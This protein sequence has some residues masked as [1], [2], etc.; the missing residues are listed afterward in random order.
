MEIRPALVFSFFA[1]GLENVSF[2]PRSNDP[3]EKG[4]ACDCSRRIDLLKTLH[5]DTHSIF[6]NSLTQDKRAEMFI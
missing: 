3:K 4:L 2:N 1:I 5:L 6:N